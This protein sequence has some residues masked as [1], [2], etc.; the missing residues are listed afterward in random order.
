M[1][2]RTASVPGVCLGSSLTWE[3][4]GTQFEQGIG[5]TSD[6]DTIVSRVRIT[7]SA[8]ALETNLQG[9]TTSAVG[10]AARGQLFTEIAPRAAAATL[11]MATGDM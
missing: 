3:R 5:R 7:L 9:Q 1:C 4:E 8:R 11:G 10:N 2:A 6:Y